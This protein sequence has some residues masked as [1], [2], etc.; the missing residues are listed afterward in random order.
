MG[1][2]T[3]IRSLVSIGYWLTGYLRRCDL[4]R[5]M[6]RTDFRH[7]ATEGWRLPKMEMIDRKWMSDCLCFT[8]HPTT[9]KGYQQGT[10]FI[11]VIS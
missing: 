10:S 4:H 7:G 6:W 5:H 3:S 8:R 11:V 2:S 9:M 1:I